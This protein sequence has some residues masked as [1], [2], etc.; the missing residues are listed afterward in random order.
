MNEELDSFPTLQD[1]VEV[2]KLARRLMIPQKKERVTESNQKIRALEEKRKVQVNLVKII[3]LLIV[4]Y[5]RFNYNSYE[6]I[7]L[8]S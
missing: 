6:I 5:I 4:N 7:T 1:N 2:E 8:N 3:V